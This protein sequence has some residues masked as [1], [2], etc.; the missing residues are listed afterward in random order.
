MV[1]TPDLTIT[2][3]DSGTAD[4]E[5]WSVSVEIFYFATLQIHFLKWWLPCSSL[6]N[7]AIRYVPRAIRAT[8]INGIRIAVNNA[9]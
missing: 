6:L 9:G 5:S 3:N 2:P 8:P 4:N 1:R 7:G